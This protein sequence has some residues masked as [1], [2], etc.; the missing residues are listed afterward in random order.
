MILCILIALLFPLI[1]SSPINTTHVYRGQAKWRRDN[2][3]L[4]FENGAVVMAIILLCIMLGGIA[5]Y[6][7]WLGFNHKISDATYGLLLPDTVHAL[8]EVERERRKKE[9]KAKEKP[10][11]NDNRSILAKIFGLHTD[12]ERE[13]RRNRLDDEAPPFLVPPR[14]PKLENG[15]Q[16]FR[17]TNRSK[18]RAERKKVPAVKKEEKEQSK[19]FNGNEKKLEVKTARDDTT[20]SPKAN[21]SN[22]MSKE[23]DTPKESTPND[24]KKE[25]TNET[26]E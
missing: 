26:K 20:H 14:R 9:E 11:N 10:V 22:K 13:A 4:E 2:K 21:D 17:Q 24:K 16:S 7:T 15:S 5:V 19:E 1:S 23:N 25:Q 12:E 3:N 6:L 18:E 8:E